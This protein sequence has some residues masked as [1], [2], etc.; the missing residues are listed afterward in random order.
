MDEHERRRLLRALTG[1][2]P[3]PEPDPAVAISDAVR[4]AWATAV[5]EAATMSEARA[6]E[7][8]RAW[9]YDPDDE[10]SHAGRV[11]Y[12][13]RTAEE[14]V[15]ARV[16]HV[17]TVAETHEGGRAARFV[18][19]YELVVTEDGALAFALHMTPNETGHVIPAGADLMTAAA[20]A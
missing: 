1:Q 2:E 15:R 14:P 3:E 12:D 10:E 16:A 6:R 11:T 7:T 17:V 4:A 13:L 8:I 18:A 9:G 19:G 20:D 5:R